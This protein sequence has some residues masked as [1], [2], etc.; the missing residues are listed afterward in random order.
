MKIEVLGYADL[1]PYKKEYYK[2]LEDT[3][4]GFLHVGYDDGDD[5]YFCDSMEPED[6]SFFRDLSWITD[7]IRDV[8]EKGYMDGRDDT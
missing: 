4:A 7:L 8:Y 2:Y 1:P 5:E 3:E 6:V